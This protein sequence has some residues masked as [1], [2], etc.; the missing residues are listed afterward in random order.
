MVLAQLCTVPELQ[1]CCGLRVAPLAA[2]AL[3]NGLI[4]DTDQITIPLPY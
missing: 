3:S 1:V 2:T 4:T